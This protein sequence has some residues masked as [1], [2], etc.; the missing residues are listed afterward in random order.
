MIFPKGPRTVEWAR[1]RSLREA[2]TS[3]K[4]ET[5]IIPYS[6][7]ASIFLFGCGPQR[8]P[9]ILPS[10]GFYPLHSPWL[11]LTRSRAHSDTKFEGVSGNIALSNACLASMILY[12]LLRYQQT[13]YGRSSIYDNAGSDKNL[14]LPSTCPSADGRREEW[15]TRFPSP[16]IDWSAILLDNRPRSA[17]CSRSRMLV[18]TQNLSA[19]KSRPVRLIALVFFK[20]GGV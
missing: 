15:E 4:V 16:D 13:P 20:F 9:S 17:T 12:A 5:Y 19:M 11:H 6:R 10:L 1:L 7:F 2:D 8:D 3:S 18:A 14:F